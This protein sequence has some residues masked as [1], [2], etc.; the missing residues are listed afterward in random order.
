M[1][2]ETNPLE[3]YLREKT[4]NFMGSMRGVGRGA[5]GSMRG[6]GRGAMEALNGEGGKGLAHT[7]GGGVAKGALGVA[8]GLAVAGA[9]MAAQKAY[10]AVTKTRDF[11]AM[12]DANPD[13]AAKH[14]ESP[15]LFNQMFSTLRTMNPSFSREPI[16][17]GAYMRQM[18]GDEEH[19]GATAVEALEHRDKMRSPLMAAFSG[20]GGKKKK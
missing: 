4:A 12:L 13:L 14:Q 18:V 8:G 20:G 10:D 17:A 3:A 2:S 7:I 16:V 1:A 15:R 9:G 5:M 11:R 19:A 6:V